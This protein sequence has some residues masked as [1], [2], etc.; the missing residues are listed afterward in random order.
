MAWLYCSK[1]PRNWS[2]VK[3]S[4]LLCQVSSFFFSI[5]FIDTGVVAIELRARGLDG[6]LPPN[7]DRFVAPLLE[8][9]KHFTA[10]VLNCRNP[11]VQTLARNHGELTFNHIQPTRSLGRVVELEALGER[12]CF[13][14]SQML[15]ERGGVV[16]VE[17]IKHQSDLGRIRILSSKFLTKQG[18]LAFGSSLIDLSK[19]AS[20]QRLDRGKQDTRAQFLVLVVL[21][22]DLAFTHR[23]WQQRVANQ[24]TGSL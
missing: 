12:E 16:G 3:G 7:L 10:Q 4:I 9:G 11:P 17:I 22:G 21:L 19:P 18:E 8:Q 5:G 20:T 1:M 15:I 14:S 2:I 13:L 23:A 6:E 24:E